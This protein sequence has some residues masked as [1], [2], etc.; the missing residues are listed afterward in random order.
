MK[1]AEIEDNSDGGV[2]AQSK[3]VCG[4]NQENQSRGKNL[5]CQQTLV[6]LQDIC[7]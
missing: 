1:V 2:N 5:R 7:G 6:F 4:Q 3:E